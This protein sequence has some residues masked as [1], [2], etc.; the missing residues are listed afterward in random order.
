M[1]VKFDKEGEFWMSFEEW[2]K[3]FTD[4]DICHFVNT[5]FFTLKK[6]WTE[7]ICFSKWSSAG[8]NGGNNWDSLSFLSN[9]QYMFDITTETP[10]T[11][12]VSLEQRDVTEG[13][14]AVGH[15][16]NTIGFYIMKVERNRQ[17][18]IHVKGEQMFKSQF[19]K[20]RNVFGTCALP[21]GRYVIIPCCANASAVGDFMLRLYTSNKTAGRELTLESPKTGCCSGKVKLVTTINVEKLDGLA[22]PEKAKGNPS[23]NQKLRAHTRRLCNKELTIYE[24]MDQVVGTQKML[25][26]NYRAKQATLKNSR[27]KNVPAGTDNTRHNGSMATNNILTED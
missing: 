10:D 21:K 13:R 6:S 25:A 11:I 15:E 22:L 17:Y 3:N 7:T 9:P 19:L 1:G 27:S 4:V 26:K 14:V 23:K 8:R 18:R 2:T 16:K 24:F 12:M 5:S 20:S